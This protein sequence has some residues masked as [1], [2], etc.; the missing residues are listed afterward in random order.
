MPPWRHRNVSSMRLLSSTSFLHAGRAAWKLLL[1]MLQLA[2]MFLR[3]YLRRTFNTF[4]VTW[5]LVLSLQVITFIYHADTVMYLRPVFVKRHTSGHPS[6]TGRAQD[7]VSSQASDRRSAN[8]ATQPWVCLYAACMLLPLPL[9]VCVWPFHRPSSTQCI[10]GT[11][12]TWC[13][14]SSWEDVLLVLQLCD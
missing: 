5:S 7:R 9:C 13:G 8:C 11:L 10:P 2:V 6:A 3:K 4:F 12:T 14:Q 1:L